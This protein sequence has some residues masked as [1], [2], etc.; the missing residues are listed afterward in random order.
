MSEGLNKRQFAVQIK[1]QSREIAEEWRRFAKSNGYSSLSALLRDSAQRRIDA[2][3]ETQTV[4]SI[5]AEVARVRS[6]VAAL[7]SEVEMVLHGKKHAIRPAL[8][9]LI[10]SAR[11]VVARMTPEQNKNARREFI[12]SAAHG[13]VRMHNP[14]LTR[15]QVEEQ[16]D[17]LGL[18]NHH[19][20]C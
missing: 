11:G 18:D 4:A 16:Y 2:I 10:E 8:E 17:K 1:F 20:Q 6:E 14:D 5:L 9:D 19:G 12:I 3:E 7:R 13:N 15:E